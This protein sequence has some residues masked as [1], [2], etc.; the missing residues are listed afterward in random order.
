MATAI[1]TSPTLYGETA[2]KFEMEAMRTEE[3]PGMLDYSHEAKVV[4]AFIKN[5]SI[6]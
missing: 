1:R 3:C 5:T 6:L 4:S 2:Q